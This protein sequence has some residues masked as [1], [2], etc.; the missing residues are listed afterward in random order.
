VEIL[1]SGVSSL[2][3]MRRFWRS[4]LYI[5]LF[6]ARR[7]RVVVGRNGNAVRGVCVGVFFYKIGTWMRGE[8]VYCGSATFAWCDKVR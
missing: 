5:A 2:L 4:C 6:L 1:D 3:K 7:V 8:T